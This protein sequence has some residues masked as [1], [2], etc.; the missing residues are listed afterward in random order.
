MGNEDQETAAAGAA[1]EKSLVS[2]RGMV[3][4]TCLSALY[5]H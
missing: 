4:R 3:A 2:V 5:R 1:T